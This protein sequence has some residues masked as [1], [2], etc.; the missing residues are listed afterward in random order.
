[1]AMFLAPCGL[2]TLTTF[3]PR[4]RLSQLVAG[5]HGVASYEV[6]QFGPNGFRRRNSTLPPKWPAAMTLGASV[7]HPNGTI[8]S[9]KAP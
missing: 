7:R 2:K 3:A 6:C 8:I 4:C 1:M 9:Q 5:R